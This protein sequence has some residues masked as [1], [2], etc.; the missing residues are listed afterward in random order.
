MLLSSVV[1]KSSTLLSIC[2]FHVLLSPTASS[3]L[4]RDM[5]GRVDHVVS[6]SLS[7]PGHKVSKVIA[8]THMS[9][10][11]IYCVFTRRINEVFC[12]SLSPCF[13]ELVVS[14]S[15]WFVTRVHK[16]SLCIFSRWCH[17]RSVDQEGLPS[18]A[19]INRDCC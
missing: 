8:F 17:C 6:R 19:F 4:F 15:D 2:V 1:V 10:D 12:G 11:A 16:L 7:L 14:F 9:Q 3:K 5:F 13:V 18:Y